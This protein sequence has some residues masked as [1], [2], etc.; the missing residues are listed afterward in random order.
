VQDKART[1]AARVTAR[2]LLELIMLYC[3]TQLAMWLSKP[4]F[5]MAFGGGG[6]GDVDNEES[7]GNETE[8]V[9]D[10][11]APRTSLNLAERL[12]RGITGE[13]ADDLESLLQKGRMALEDDGGPGAAK[14]KNLSPILIHF[15]EEHLRS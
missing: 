5:D 1:S 4:E 9:K 12:R 8:G 10:R 6:G 7:Q 15:F 11:K 13:M 14:H 3:V 2:N